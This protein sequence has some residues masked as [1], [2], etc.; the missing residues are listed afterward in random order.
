MGSNWF[1]HDYIWRNL[2][3]IWH[4]DLFVRLQAEAREA[5][6]RLWSPDTCD[7]GA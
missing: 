5:S 4:A 6:R 2:K 1:L 3:N 7:G